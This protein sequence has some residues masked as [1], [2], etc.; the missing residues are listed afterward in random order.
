MA[1][2]AHSSRYARLVAG[3]AASSFALLGLLGMQQYEANTITASAVDHA[4]VLSNY[5]L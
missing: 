3:F 4:I 5:G 2:H 1:S